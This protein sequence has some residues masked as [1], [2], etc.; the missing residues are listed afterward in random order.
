MSAVLITLSILLV[1]CAAAALSGL[2]DR[3]TLVELVSDCKREASACLSMLAELVRGVKSK[4]LVGQFKCSDSFD[5]FISRI[6]HET[7][8]DPPGHSVDLYAPL[9]MEILN[10]RVRT[11][12][13]KQDDNVYDAFAVEI[14]GS[15]HAPDDARH[16][17]LRVS[18]L[19]VTDGPNGE[20]VL[21]GSRHGASLGQ[22]NAPE[23]S[24]LAELGRLPSEV[25]KLDDWT[26]VAS[27][28]TDGQVFPRGGRRM[29]QFSTL[30]LSDA[31][32]ELAVARCNFV[33]ENPLP[34]YL[35][36]RE[37]AE[38]AKVLTVALGFA[39]SAADNK[40]YECEIELI[41]KWAFENISG[42]Q[43][44]ESGQSDAD[45]E[46]AL[47]KTVAY[48]SEGKKL[49]TFKL[50]QEMVETATVGQ[51]YEALALC[52]H[53]A[54]ANGSVTAEEMAMLKDLASWL[55]VDAARFRAMMEKILPIEMHEVMEL[56]DFLGITSDM[57]R[58]K[59]R[60][61][62]N[63]EYCKWN[64][65]VT[66]ANPRIQTQADQMLK[67]IAEARGQYVTDG[68]TRKV[69]AATRP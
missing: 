41:K 35:D 57:S 24:H 66:S 59:T 40:L 4:D 26:V 46:R 54:K 3:R 50:C 48:F 39:V 58:E 19:D 51:R 45:L 33:Y 23:F 67:L 42:S 55:E 17:T 29:L 49:D 44:S 47:S 68:H 30:I 15:I 43:A 9:D 11:I 14:C 13:L 31:G 28:R 16:A 25:T 34:G 12:E 69:G 6:S 27:L 20:P 65:R 53:V 56:N 21:A 5:D 10:C 64:S 63:K 7:E 38:R 60:R 61:H 62:L 52:L 36:L 32:R 1:A 2:I 8:P 22:S 18:I 37:N